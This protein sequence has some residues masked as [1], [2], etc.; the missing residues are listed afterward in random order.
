MSLKKVIANKHPLVEVLGPVMEFCQA[1]EIINLYFLLNKEVN[2][3]ALEILGLINRPFETQ[4]KGFKPLEATAILR[5]SEQFLKDNGFVDED[6]EI[7]VN[8]ENSDGQYAIDVALLP[9]IPNKRLIIEGL[10]CRGFDLNLIEDKKDVAD[11]LVEFKIFKVAFEIAMN[12]IGK[13]KFNI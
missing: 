5:F 8:M 9:D 6:K 11:K 12:L 1:K 3:Q 4:L 13:N 2:K 10:L 7:N